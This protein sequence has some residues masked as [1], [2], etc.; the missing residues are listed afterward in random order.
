MNT[1][2]SDTPT[3]DHRTPTVLSRVLARWPSVVG[4]AALVATSADGVDAHI[5]ATVIMGAALCYLAAAA[6]G[7][8][9]AG[10]IAIPVVFGLLLAAMA[11]P[12]VD[13]IVMLLVL[14]VLLVVVGLIRLPRSGWRELGLQAA[15]FAGFTALGLTA[16]MVTPVLAAH[17]AALAAIG[18]GVWDLVHHRRDKVVNRSLTE[19]CMVLDFGLGAVTLIITW[20]TLAG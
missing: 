7:W 20:I 19:T 1:K 2:I 14:A 8:R 18:H 4:L 17:L 9:P 12:A 3:H 15:G 11:I 10:W 6:V 5:T 16:M 13:A